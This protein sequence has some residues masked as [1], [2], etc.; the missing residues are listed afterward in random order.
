MQL[1][2][3]IPTV[4][5]TER[6]GVTFVLSTGLGSS[7]AGLPDDDDDD[8]D[9][10]FIKRSE[11]PALASVLRDCLGMVVSLALLFTAQ[12]VCFTRLAAAPVDRPA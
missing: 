5:T 9:I 4:E 11:D 2:C 3:P 1:F 7:Y 12:W 8:E 10:P 6:F